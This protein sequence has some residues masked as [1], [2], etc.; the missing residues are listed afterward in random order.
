MLNQSVLRGLEAVNHSEELDAFLDAVS[1][2]LDTASRRRRRPL[3]LRPAQR[4]EIDSIIRDSVCETIEV[5]WQLGWLTLHVVQPVEPDPSPRPR[6][7]HPE[8]PEPEGGS[9]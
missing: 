1:R 9:R 6:L 8:R 7:V 2:R 4:T 5:L 3:R